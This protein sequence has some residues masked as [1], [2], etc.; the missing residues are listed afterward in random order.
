MTVGSSIAAGPRL[1]G[2]RSGEFYSRVVSEIDAVGW[3]KLISANDS[4]SRLSFQTRYACELDR[5]TASLVA[6]S[7]IRTGTRSDASTGS[8]SSCLRTTLARRLCAQL[9]CRRPSRCSG[10]RRNQRSP[11]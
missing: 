3:D 10:M 8:I 5:D 11:M 1:Q 2:P 6:Y 4:L 9:T 7:A